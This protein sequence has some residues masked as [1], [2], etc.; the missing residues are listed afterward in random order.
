MTPARPLITG[1][2][3]KVWVAGSHRAQ[4]LDNSSLLTRSTVLG[5]VRGNH[6]RRHTLQTPE[7]RTGIRR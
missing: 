1:S 2:V 7:P 4:E 6:E 5:Q 3:K